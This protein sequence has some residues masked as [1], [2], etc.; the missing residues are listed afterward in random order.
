[1]IDYSK[2]DAA[3]IAAINVGFSTFYAINRRGAVA[4]VA[5][6]INPLE[7]WRVVER[8]MQALRKAG[9]IAYAG[10]EWSVVKEPS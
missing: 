9:R 4:S 5:E 2:L 6:R 8:R 7:P 1:M 10:R 3:I